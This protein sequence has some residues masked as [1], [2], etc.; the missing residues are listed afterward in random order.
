MHELCDQSKNQNFT[1]LLTAWQ[2]PSF[3]CHFILWSCSGRSFLHLC[4]FSIWLLACF[5][6][7]DMVLWFP[8]V[9]W[10]RHSSIHLSLC[11][12]LWGSGGGTVASPP[13]FYYCFFIGLKVMSHR[14]DWLKVSDSV[15][16]S[17]WQ[18]CAI[19]TSVLVP[20]TL[21]SPEGN[22]VLAWQL[23]PALC[24]L[25]RLWQRLLVTFI[26][27]VVCKIPCQSKCLT[28]FYWNN[29]WIKN[30]KESCLDFSCFIHPDDFGLTTR[31]A[32]CWSGGWGAGHRKWAM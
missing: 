21:T 5:M 6:S 16:S 18:C 30:S 13:L 2:N 29:K 28:T 15:T 17:S 7:P 19:T 25:P 20:N 31:Q 27:L 24:F 32:M 9:S 4:T 1:Y 23:L 8:H 12:A 14:G 26:S 3:C 10:H 22:S 11:W